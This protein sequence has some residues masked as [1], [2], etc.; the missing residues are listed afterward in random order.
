MSAV[1]LRV[2]GDS[3]LVYSESLEIVPEVYLESSQ[4]V[5]EVYSESSEPV[6]E[7]YFVSSEPL[8]K[9]YSEFVLGVSSRSS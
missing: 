9:I 1:V 5:S 3:S 6:P 8:P 2:L 4:P 7:V